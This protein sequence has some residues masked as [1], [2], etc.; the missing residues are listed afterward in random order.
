MFVL[1]FEAPGELRLTLES[2]ALQIARGQAGLYAA[3]DP[4]KLVRDSANNLSGLAAE[5]DGL[6]AAA[7]PAASGGWFPPPGLTSAEADQLRTGAAQPIKTSVEQLRG[8]APDLQLIYQRLKTIP[9]LLNSYGKT[10]ELARQFERL[11][12]GVEAN[13]SAL[14]SATNSAADALKDASLSLSNAV[15]LLKLVTAKPADGG[16]TAEND[17]G[18]AGADDD[19]QNKAA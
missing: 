8:E 13:A 12:V 14:T 3:L 9:A 7:P 5:I 4:A 6:A 11:S 17:L 16:A 19:N 1:S 2:V 15:M 18:A 10:P